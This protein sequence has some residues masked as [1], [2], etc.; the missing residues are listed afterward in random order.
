ML[1]TLKQDMGYYLPSFAAI[2]S[3][4]GN[5]GHSS[6]KEEVIHP[7]LFRSKLDVDGALPLAEVLMWLQY[8]WCRLWR[9]PKGC[10]APGF[11]LLVCLPSFL[12]NST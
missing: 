2:T 1:P 11:L 6:F 10:P 3:Q 4:V 5:P 8:F 9:I 7:N 12:D